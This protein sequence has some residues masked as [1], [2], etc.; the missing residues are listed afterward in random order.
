MNSLTLTP[1]GPTMR[2]DPVDLELYLSGSHTKSS[3]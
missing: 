2:P 3:A 1:N